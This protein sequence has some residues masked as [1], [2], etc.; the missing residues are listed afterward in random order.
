MSAYKVITLVLRAGFSRPNIVYAIVA[1]LGV[2]LKDTIAN[3]CCE[4]VDALRHAFGSF[5]GES[6][7]RYF[8]EVLS[9]VRGA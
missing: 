5:A 8:P 1:G 6:N 4:I 7:Y 3:C 9:Q 2:E